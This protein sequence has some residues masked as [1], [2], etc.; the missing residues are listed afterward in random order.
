MTVTDAIYNLESCNR[1]VFD[2]E[3]ELVKLREER[4]AAERSVPAARQ[5]LAD[6]APAAVAGIDAAKSV[7]RSLVGRCARQLRSVNDLRGHRAYA[8]ELLERVR[9]GELILIKREARHT[10]PGRLEGL[11]VRKH[12]SK[13]K[14]PDDPE[15]RLA[16]RREIGRQAQ[17]ASAAA[18]RARKYARQLGANADN[19]ESMPEDEYANLREMLSRLRT[20]HLYDVLPTQPRTFE[21][22]MLVQL[23]DDIVAAQQL[24]VSLDEYAIAKQRRISEARREAQRRGVEVRKQRKAAGGTY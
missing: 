15:E 17:A 20:R 12:V 23:N 5:R 13:Y 19:R 7:L 16:R 6:G 9:Q 3:N 21:E 10:A 4:E 1:A 11:Y 2:A 18:R 24:G 14:L 22:R 8:V